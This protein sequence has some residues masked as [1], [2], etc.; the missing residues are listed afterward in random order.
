MG[1]RL[2]GDGRKITRATA[3]AEDLAQQIALWGYADAR[4]ANAKLTNDDNIGDTT[5]QLESTTVATPLVDHGEADLTLGGAVWSGIPA[6]DLT[7]NGFERYWNVS[8]ND[9][10]VPGTLLDSN[11]N[12]VADAMRIAV[13]VRWPHGG[14]WRRIV[15]LTTKVNPAEGFN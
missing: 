4:L 1:L 10:Q 7:A 5:F 6:A 11:G 2:D 9:P 13:I 14:G 15:V 8:F 12:L 3:I